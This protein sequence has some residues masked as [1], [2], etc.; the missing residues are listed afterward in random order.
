MADN[1]IRKQFNVS[2]RAYSNGEYRKSLH[3]AQSIYSRTP[4]NV[5]NLILLAALHFQKRNLSESLFYSQQAI[6]VESNCAEAY[7][8]MGNCLKEMN[9]LESARN[10][11]HKAIRFNPRFADSYQNLGLVLFLSGKPKEAI[12]AFEVALSLDP[13][14][15]DA[16]CNIGAVLKV[17]GRYNEAKEKY[18]QAI[19][20]NPQCAIG[21]SNLGGIFVNIGDYAQAVTCYDHALKIAPNFC[22]ALSNSANAIFKSRSRSRRRK[23]DSKDLDLDEALVQEVHSRYERALEQRADF[24]LSIGCH[25]IFNLENGLQSKEEVIKALRRVVL[26]DDTCFDAMSNLAALYFQTWRLDDSLKVLLRVLKQKP[27]HW[28]AYNNLGNVLKEKVRTCMHCH[29]TLDLALN[30][31]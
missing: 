31:R 24:V 11:F 28:C 22:D 1:N 16:L 25:A 18:L 27:E 20:I 13:S 9:D 10:F 23:G 17:L 15:C 14:H 3:I 6:R 2:L 12:E 30:D 29:H 26:Q 5:D 8:I 19:R 7:S 21:W 4:S